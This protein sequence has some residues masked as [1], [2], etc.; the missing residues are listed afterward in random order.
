MHKKNESKIPKK[1]LL[2]RALAEALSK[3]KYFAESLIAG[4]R[5]R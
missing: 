3:E 5:Q 4:A 1:K 2:Q